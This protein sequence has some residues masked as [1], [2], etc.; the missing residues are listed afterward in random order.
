MT[1]KVH[2]TMKTIYIVTTGDCEDYQ[3]CAVFDN[4]RQAKKAA[5]FYGGEIEEWPLNYEDEG[6]K[7]FTSGTKG[8]V[9]YFDDNSNVVKSLI[10]VPFHL[11]PSVRE[12]TDKSFPSQYSEMD[13]KNHG[14]Y[15]VEVFARDEE[16]AMK[17]AT[18]KLTQYKAQQAGVC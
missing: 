7:L 11:T 2:T 18:E 10:T 5:E 6:M 9:F 12:F 15:R 4:E 13:K 14:R 8:H 16:H 1:H 17:L 3:T